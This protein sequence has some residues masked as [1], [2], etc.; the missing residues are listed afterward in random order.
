MAGHVL[1]SSARLKGEVLE[2]RTLK[3]C[4]KKMQDD[5]PQDAFFLAV[6]AWAF[7]RRFC[8]KSFSFSKTWAHP[9][10]LALPF[11]KLKNSAILRCLKSDFKICLQNPFTLTT[12]CV[13]QDGFQAPSFSPFH[14]SPINLA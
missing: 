2:G 3:R 9:S 14:V 11:K 4:T 7:Q 12:K 13:I 5:A 10:K 1:H 8:H 6:Q